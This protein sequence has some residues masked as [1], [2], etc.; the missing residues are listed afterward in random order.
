VAGPEAQVR[1]R[2]GEVLVGRDGL[3]LRP[4]GWMTMEGLLSFLRI[5]LII[6]LALVLLV[7]LGFAAYTV[8]LFAMWLVGLV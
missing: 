8:F 4:V 5:A 3:R 2:W 6:A 7:F 1:G